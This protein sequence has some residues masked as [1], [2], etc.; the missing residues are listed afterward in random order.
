MPSDIDDG[1]SNKRCQNIVIWSFVCSVRLEETT[2][3]LQIMATALE[4]EKKKTDMLLHQMLPEK[5]A[6]Q[7]REGQK[8]AAGSYHD[9]YIGE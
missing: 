3:A 4:R 7:L 2:A 1:V 6:D 8:V 9:S 5:V